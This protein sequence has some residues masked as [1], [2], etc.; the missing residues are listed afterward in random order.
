MDSGTFEYKY[1]YIIVMEHC[2][3]G[4]LTDKIKN[5]KNEIL[6]KDSTSSNITMPEY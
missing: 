1:I 5:Y 3:N 2:A 4:D 6:E